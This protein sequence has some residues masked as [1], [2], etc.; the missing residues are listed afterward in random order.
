LKL[1]P[2]EL[3]AQRDFPYWL[4]AAAWNER[5]RHATWRDDDKAKASKRKPLKTFEEQD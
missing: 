5:D 3:L 1:T 4:I 2:G